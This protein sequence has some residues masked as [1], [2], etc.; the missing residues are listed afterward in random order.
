[1]HIPEVMLTNDPKALAD[2]LEYL[3]KSIGHAHSEDVATAVTPPRATNQGKGLMTKNGAMIPVISIGRNTSQEAEAV[4]EGIDHSMKIKGPTTPSE[5]ARYKSDIKKALNVSDEPHLKGLNKEVRV[6]PE[7]SDGPTDDSSSL[8]SE[9]TVE[10]ISSDDDESHVDDVDVSMHAEDAT[11]IAV[12]VAK[13]QILEQ[14]NEVANFNAHIAPARQPQADVQI[15][16]IQPD[17]PVNILSHTYSSKEFTK[18]FL[19]EPEH[20]DMN[21]FQLLKNPSESE[22]QS[23]VDVLVT[24]ATLA[25]LRHPSI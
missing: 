18:Q 22:V 25:A 12:I 2:Y 19:N 17:K 3:T 20:V 23:M 6:T 11:D 13:E 9:I 4:E 16:D 14:H 7:V 15:S 24:Q 1:M 21:L 5:A 10:D 8:S